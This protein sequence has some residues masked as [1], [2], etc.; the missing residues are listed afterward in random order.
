MNLTYAYIFLGFDIVIKQII[1]GNHLVK[2][3]VSLT[4]LVPVISRTIAKPRNI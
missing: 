3:A 4:R 1:V 2:P